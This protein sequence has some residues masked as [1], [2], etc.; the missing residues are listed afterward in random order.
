M[1]RTRT[2]LEARNLLFA[3]SWFL[4]E[5]YKDIMSVLYI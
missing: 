2:N 4:D 5:Y 3:L 1:I